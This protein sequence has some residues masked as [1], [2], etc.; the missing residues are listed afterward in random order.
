MPGESEITRLNAPGQI[1]AAQLRYP[2][3]SQ[4]STRL[5]GEIEQDFFLPCFAI[6]HAYCLLEVFNR[7]PD[8]HGRRK[9]SLR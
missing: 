6:G 9:G 3:K 1:G 7:V 4:A 2:A 5:I 8:T